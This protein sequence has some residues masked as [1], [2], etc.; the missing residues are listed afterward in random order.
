MDR[1]RGD[2]RH[3]RRRRASASALIPGALLFALAL[4]RS[5]VGVGAAASTAWPT[6]VHGQTDA[7]AAAAGAQGK[8]VS[9]QK[10][11]TGPVGAGA[12]EGD[13]KPTRPSV[14]LGLPGAQYVTA[15]DLSF[16]ASNEYPQI[17][18]KAWA[19]VAEPYRATTFTASSN[20]GNPGKDVFK[21]SFEDG[22]VIEGRVVTHIFT[23]VGS[24][25]VSL[26]QTIVSTGEIRQ[27]QASVMVKYVRREIRQ[28]TYKDREAFFDAMEKLYRLPTSE[29]NKLYGDDYKGIQFFVQMHLDGAGVQDCD[30]WHDDA[31]IMTHHVGYTLL[32]EQALQVV[33]PSVSIPYWEYTVES[34]AGLTDYGESELFRDDW[35][36]AA[37]PENGLHTVDKGRW[38]YLPVM[39]D[40]W[41]YVHNPYGLLR[42]PWNTDPTPYVTRH[43]M[44]NAEDLTNLVTCGQYQSCFDQVTLAGLNN[45]LNGGTHGP[46]HIKLGG[47]WNDPEE[48]LAIDLGY[49]DQVIL[50][51]KYLWR[52]GYLRLPSSCTTE[53]HGV[54]DESTCRAGCPAEV[55]ENLGMKP[56][57][58]LMDC[59]S[60]HWISGKTGGII[61]YD[62]ENEKFTVAGHE[63][64]EDFQ[65]ALWL[66]ILDSLCDPGHVGELY[67][68]AAP[69]DP[70]FWVIHPTAD[71][72]LAWRRKLA[73]EQP[74]LW[75][76][77]ETWD[78]S[79]GWV[80]GETGVTCDWDNVQEG[81]LDMPTCTSGICGGHN[82][83][84]L[85]PFKV[86]LKGE[87]VQMTNREW[88]NFIYPDN[89]DLPYMYNE[90]AW[91]HCAAD[92]NYIGTKP[93]EN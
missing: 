34:S 71:R 36:G 93:T 79:H 28:L 26:S 87:T 43:N 67:T 84:D 19:H 65:D 92:G 13:G 62:E 74:D 44:T 91:D 15:D 48:S 30:H 27:I 80:V 61:V 9:E 38:A 70:L 52:K 5:C 41:D 78:Y 77:D 22:T 90:F 42:T 73:T 76:L 88:Y 4:L 49:A 11:A 12:S 21:W 33:D 18:N 83:D 25:E 56:Y 53:E 35:F 72:F 81:S 82:E 86:K 29:G 39:Q 14:Q 85:L 63:D 16:E 57:D 7:A 17:Q 55:Y 59:L 6:K 31:G 75:T 20:L 69:Y 54:G 2:K 47:E 89:D 24:H 1:T 45:C 8:G 37:S 66:R 3:V 58:V 50:M 51:A 23:A 68:S 40:A 46:V 32:F 60:L 64:D 10:R